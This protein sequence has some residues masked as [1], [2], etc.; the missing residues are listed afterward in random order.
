MFGAPPELVAGVGAAGYDGCSTASN[1]TLDQGLDGIKATLDTFD[2]ARL[3]HTGSARSA[4]EA[5]TPRIYSVKGVKVANLSYAYG[6]NGYRLPAGAPWAANQIDPNRILADARRAAAAGA[7]LV[8]VSLHWGT[9]NVHAPNAEQRTLAPVLT[10]SP[11]IDV[12]IGHHAHVVQPIE[13]INGKPVV[14]GLGNQLSNQLRTEQRDGLTVVLTAQPGAG[15]RYRVTGLKAVPTYMDSVGWR[16]LPI[17]QALADP[18]TAP[19]LRD[20]LR[21]SYERTMATVQ[22]S[23]PVL[24]LTADPT[25]TGL[26]PGPSTPLL[27]LSAAAGWR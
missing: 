18:A 7:Q 3:G 10:A 26:T 11:D 6:F 16:V 19:A 24:G 20:A 17:P 13:W 23:G 14:F 12:L 5:A 1:H 8:V 27:C 2:F 21:A 4:Q 9:E 15:G 22:A 25:P